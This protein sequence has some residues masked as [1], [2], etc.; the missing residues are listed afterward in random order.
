MYHQAQ[1]YVPDTCEAKQSETSSLEQRKVDCRTKYSKAFLKTRWGRG[2]PEYVI[3]LCTI[4]WWVDVEVTGQL[5]I[6]R[7]Q[8]WWGRLLAHDHQVTNFF[9]VVV[10][11]HL[12][13]SGNVH[14]ILL[15]GYIREVLQDVGEGSMPGRPHR[16]WLGYYACRASHV[17]LW[18]RHSQNASKSPHL[19]CFLNIMP[20]TIR[21]QLVFACTCAHPCL[22]LCCPTVCSPSGS[23]LGFSSQEY[24][25]GLPFP[26]SGDLSNPGIKP[27]SPAL[28]G[29][30]FIAEPSLPLSFPWGKPHLLLWV[31]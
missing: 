2:I 13:S 1:V 11:Q 17:F 28:A 25:S 19:G 26:P 31:G 8:R 29:G 10:F 23:S 12:R 20:C 30:F 24:W 15:G 6:L 4:L 27:A 9:H 22:T 18:C 16:V 7:H 21:T 3:S 14:G 5:S